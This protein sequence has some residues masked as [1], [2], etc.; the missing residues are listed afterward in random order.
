MNN[1]NEGSKSDPS[2]S[3]DEEKEDMMS[4]DQS[5]PDYLPIYKE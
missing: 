4:Q 3:N 2:G 1:I 5:Q